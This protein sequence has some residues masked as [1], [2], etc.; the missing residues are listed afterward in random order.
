MGIGNRRIAGSFVLVAA[1]VASGGCTSDRRLSLIDSAHFAPEDRAKSDAAKLVASVRGKAAAKA[2]G[3]LNA[4]MASR[5]GLWSVAGSKQATAD[6]SATDARAKAAASAAAERAAAI[7]KSAADRAR[8]ARG[9]AD[10]S[11]QTLAA[12]AKIA[13]TRADEANDAKTQAVKD[14]QFAKS[15][16]VVAWRDAMVADSKNTDLQSISTENLDALARFAAAAAPPDPVVFKTGS[17]NQKPASFWKSLDL[18]SPI[19]LTAGAL[20]DLAKHVVVEDVDPVGGSRFGAEVIYGD[21]HSIV[22]IGE[23]EEFEV[24]I[25]YIAIDTFTTGR[26]RDSWGGNGG[27]VSVQTALNALTGS[28]QL[29]KDDTKFLV[30]E[31]IKRRSPFLA[32]AKGVAAGRPYVERVEDVAEKYLAKIAAANSTL[33]DL[34]KKLQDIADAA[35][36]KEDVLKK[37]DDLRDATKKEVDAWI[38]GNVKG[39]KEEKDLVKQFAA[40][41]VEAVFKEIR[42][43]IPSLLSSGANGW[44]KSTLSDAQR[45]LGEATA[46]LDWL[47][48]FGVDEQGIYESAQ[49]IVGLA[50]ADR[51]TTIE[52]ENVRPSFLQFGGDTPAGTAA[53]VLGRP[54][55]ADG[56]QE[57]EPQ[58]QFTSGTAFEKPETDMATEKRLMAAAVKSALDAADVAAPPPPP[59]PQPTVAPPAPAETLPSRAANAVM[60]RRGLVY[61]GKLSDLARVGGAKGFSF[62]FLMLDRG[63]D[64]VVRAL[65]ILKQY[66]DSAGWT[67]GGGVSEVKVSAIVDALAVLAQKIAEDK[68]ELRAIDVRFLSQEPTSG[69]GARTEIFT[70]APC[71]VLVSRNLDGKVFGAVAQI[72]IRKAA[73]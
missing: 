48:R 70:L 1:G 10:S 26:Y 68:V 47:G 15:E 2:H 61:R 34:E 30:E 51:L 72:T 16:A 22:P 35:A 64:Q 42:E 69:A 62:S 28:G 59:A 38:D 33:K 50:A 27:A 53:T 52:F 14:A 56:T 55:T 49:M 71:T 3:D 45:H 19:S 18:I 44:V 46:V 4:A 5:G 23:Q 57:L 66:S 8:D 60:S 21:R 20:W 58:G 54:R 40:T 29:L 65:N 73:D 36:K 25:D 37:V 12:L 11:V 31:T 7:A 43:A 39:D 41:V 6:Q 32:L 63:D 17:Q 67:V 13:R 9:D 24:A